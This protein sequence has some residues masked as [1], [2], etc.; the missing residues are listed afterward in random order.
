MSRTKVIHLDPAPGDDP[1]DD[2][3][4]AL[5]R[6]LK[7]Y[8]RQRKATKL[9]TFKEKGVQLLEA[10]PGVLLVVAKTD[11]HYVIATNKGP[12]NYWPSTGRFNQASEKSKVS[13]FEGFY[14]WLRKRLDVD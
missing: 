4:A 12:F 5:W 1:D 6:A 2:S 14:N 13:N 3:D 7:H 11:T 9:Q 10:L 8:Q